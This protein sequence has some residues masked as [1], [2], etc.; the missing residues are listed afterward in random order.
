VRGRLLKHRMGE[1]YAWVGRS[2]LTFAQVG[3]IVG[4]VFDRQR[5]TRRGLC[6][7]RGDDQDGWATLVPEIVAQTRPPSR[8]GGCSSA[9]TWQE[10]S[11]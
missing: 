11:R 10:V 8:C 7:A 3:Y 4:A 6:P 2:V 9:E 5:K 1:G